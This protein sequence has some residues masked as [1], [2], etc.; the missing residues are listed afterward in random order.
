MKPE[1]RRMLVYVGETLVVSIVLRGRHV[2]TLWISP[3]VEPLEWV[4]RVSEES[5]IR[6]V[7]SVV[8]Y[9]P[10][11]PWSRALGGVLG[12]Q[13]EPWTRGSGVPRQLVDFA[14]TLDA[15]ATRLLGE[16]GG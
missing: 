7:R 6:E 1:S 16:Q 13:M 12:P 11:S 9:P 4:S 15:E 10:K 3:R 8:I 5:F 2:D 14:A